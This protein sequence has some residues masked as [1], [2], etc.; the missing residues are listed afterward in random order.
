MYKVATM[1]MVEERGV[2]LWFCITIAW[3]FRVYFWH[4]FIVKN[5]RMRKLY[6]FG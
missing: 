4:V 3:V 5:K 2:L 1:T 6:F